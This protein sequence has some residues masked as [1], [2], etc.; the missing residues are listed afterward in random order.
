MDKLE[1]LFMRYIDDSN[2]QESFKNY[3]DFIEKYEFYNIDDFKDDDFNTLW[4]QENPVSSLR[5]YN[6]NLKGSEIERARELIDNLTKNIK[7]N[8]SLDSYVDSYSEMENALSKGV[9]LIRHPLLFNR[10]FSTF[11]PKELLSVPSN[12]KFNNILKFFKQHYDIH[13]AGKDMSWFE[14]NKELKHELC[15]HKPDNWPDEIDFSK[16]INVAVWHIAADMQKLTPADVEAIENTDVVEN[17]QLNEGVRMTAPLNLI[18]YGPPGTGKTHK[19]QTLFGEYSS[20]SAELPRED[21]LNKY[22]DD[23]SW[24]QIVTLCILDMEKEYVKVPEITN[25]EYFICKAKLNGRTS[26]LAQTTWSELQN[27]TIKESETVGFK[28]N[29][30]NDPAIFNKTKNSEWFI[31]EEKKE[32]IEDLIEL[33]KTIKLKAHKKEKIKR[34]SVVTFH[35]SFGYEEFIEGLS[36]KTNNDGSLAYSVKKGVFYELC[37]KAERSPKEK[38][39]I[40]IDEINRGNISKIFGELITLIEKDK[41][42]GDG[43]EISITLPYSNEEF[44][45][46]NNVDIIGTMNTADRSL[47]MMDTALRR[48][49]DF[50]E[51]MPDPSILNTNVNSIDLQ[52]LLTKLNERIEI[53][54][55]REHTLGHAFFIDVKTLQDLG[56][57]FKNKIIPLLQEY[58][59][60]DWSKIRLVLGD[61]QKKNSGN[62]FIHEEVQ[63]TAKLREM[64][65]SEQM[66]EQQYDQEIKKYILNEVAFDQIS[67]Y[68]GIYEVEKNNSSGNEND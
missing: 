53:L 38:F 43:N 54:Y 24:W 39:A 22:L 64:F 10:I 59:F 33:N 55:D 37:K 46:P 44:Y 35:Q 5:P 4:L 28:G 2:L 19:L 11:N 42:K 36:A 68:T 67:A 66:L 52:K 58:F 27:H 14:K 26:N 49:F 30:K 45:V 16:W 57:V 51:M 41:R 8:P 47:A 48:R 20:E 61:N 56:K 3:S 50:E 29:D 1:K 60:E 18:L 31:V 65:G 32:L 15:K 23:L 63:D 9:F 21:F 62:Q 13:V 34:Y 6:G 7:Q 40:F 17:E 12:S 25:H